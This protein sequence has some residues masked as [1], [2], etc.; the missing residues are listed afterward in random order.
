MLDRIGKTPGMVDV[1]SFAVIGS[2]WRSEFFLRL[3]RTAP[4][5]FRCVGVVT[6]TSSRGDEVTAQWGVPT[7]QSFDAPRAP[8]TSR[9]W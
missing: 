3:A 4:E 5:R 9:S 1:T 6:R 8:R 7:F 2:G